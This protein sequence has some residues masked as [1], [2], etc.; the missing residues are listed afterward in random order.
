MG[1]NGLLR[2]V[3]RQL[4][5][6]R[7]L[8]LRFG[9]ASGAWLTERAA[10]AALVTAVGAAVPQARLDGVRLGPAEPLA[11]EP[12]RLAVPGPPSA[13]PPQPLL[14]SG[15]IAAYPAVPLPELAD[16]VRAT[17]AEVAVGRLG[18]DVAAVDL[19]VAELL[20]EPPEPAGTPTGPPGPPAST[21]AGGPGADAVAEAV[22]A[23]AGV[24]ELSAVLDGW[25]GAV[26]VSDETE[27]PA[28][29]VRLQ[30][31]TEGERPLAP[32]VDEVTEVAAA[33]A[34]GAGGRPP[35]PVLVALLVT[36]LG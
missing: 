6:G 36:E 1:D 7:L 34:A 26:R 21:A 2:A 22:R 3:R 28:R 32:L 17:L 30:V 18:L 12:P 10:R 9:E 5:L 20:T 19:T 31:A 13:L 35:G 25:L 27:P 16:R 15:E 4:G 33:T 8:P 29:L 23:V 24:R 14:L 11:A